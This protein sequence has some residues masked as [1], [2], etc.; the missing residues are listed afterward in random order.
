MEHSLFLE[1][2]K[3]LLKLNLFSRG[4]DRGPIERNH[5]SK[6]REVKGERSE[7]QNF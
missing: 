1:E 6:V 4:A 7:H 2:R 5:L 3:G